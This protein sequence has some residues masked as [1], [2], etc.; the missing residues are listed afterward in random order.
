MKNIC[1]IIPVLNP[2]SK[3]VS[4]VSDLIDKGAKHIVV[5]NDGSDEGCENIFSQ[6][7]KFSCIILSHKKNR[8][9]GRALKT[10]FD[11][12]INNY[13]NDIGL[14]TVDADGQHLVKDVVRLAA[15]LNSIDSDTI[16]LGSRSFDSDTPFRSR[17]GNKIT[18]YLFY[19][20]TGI[21]INDTQTGLRA[22]PR[23]LIKR[24]IAIDGERYEYEL[25]VLL[26]LRDNKIG[27][28]E[29]S[30]KTIYIDNNKTSH[31]R[32]LV[33]SFKIYFL[34]IS[35]FVFSFFRLYSF[36]GGF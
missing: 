32:P 7:E 36:L 1:I 15:R 35:I 23:N 25:N 13:K 11:Y 10:G 29:E 26:G 2:T 3:I 24:L 14:V 21:K 4:L 34:F 22:I 33:D 18:K 20:L 6:L 5:I 19:F 8:G 16:F 31:F 17:F 30:I 9:K 12:F 28:E 27:V